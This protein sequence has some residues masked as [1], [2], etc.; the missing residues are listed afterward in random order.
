MQS[1]NELVP[2]SP[3]ANL[4]VSAEILVSLATGPFLLALLGGKVLGQLMQEL[5]QQSEELFRGDR[6][7]LLNFPLPPTSSEL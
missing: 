4:E 3:Q 5:G 7:P 6:L 2:D 1:S